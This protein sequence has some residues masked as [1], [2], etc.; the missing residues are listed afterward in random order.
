MGDETHRV[1]LIDDERRLVEVLAELF[2]AEGWEAR[3][4]GDAR[5]ALSECL[6]G[7]PPPVIVTDYDM[8]YLDGGS[9]VAE[10]VARLG[11]DAPPVV[12]ITG[13]PGKIDLDEEASFA[14][15]LVK[16]F[17]FGELFAVVDEVRNRPQS[18][19][20][21]LRIKA[22]PADGEKRKKAV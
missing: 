21:E 11:S 13:Y 17:R 10:L 15:I 14:N 6:R 9:F 8:P 4:F 5:L 2:R 22:T 7:E 19:E 20:S 12:C 1:W 3:A 18:R 16:P